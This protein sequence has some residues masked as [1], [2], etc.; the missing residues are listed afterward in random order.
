M[1]TARLLQLQRQGRPVRQ[2]QVVVICPSRELNVRDSIPVQEFVERRLVWIER[3]SERLPPSVPPLPRALG[4]LLTPEDQRP[5]ARRRSAPARSRRPQPAPAPTPLRQPQRG[6]T[7]SRI[8]AL[9]LGDVKVLAKARHDVQGPEDLHAW[10][11]GN[12]T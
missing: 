3:L 11:K 8:Q 6:P 1:P 2:W 9:H 5:P 4:M 7:D 10:L 12:N